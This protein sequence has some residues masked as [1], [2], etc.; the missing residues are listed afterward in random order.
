M[1]TNAPVRSDSSARAS[2]RGEARLSQL[3]DLQLRLRFFFG[4]DLGG[5]A[6]LLERLDQ[7]AVLYFA[8]LNFY[9]GLIREGHFRADDT[10]NF[11]ERRLH[12]FG[13]ING[14]SH[15]GDGEIDRFLR[16]AFRGLQYSAFR[17][18]V[19][20]FFYC[21]RYRQQQNCRTEHRCFNDTHNVDS[22]RKRP[23][24]ARSK[25]PHASALSDTPQERDF[26]NALMNG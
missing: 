24:R 7:L 18:E 4:F 12:S 25:N 11:G 15:A 2:T 26:A 1:E 8:L 14:S 9:H 16:L 19:G 20:C 21:V 17:N 3:A 22:E 10:G 13:A 5:I 23:G 6:S